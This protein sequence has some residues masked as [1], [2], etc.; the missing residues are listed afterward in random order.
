MREYNRYCIKLA[1][2]NNEA[3]SEHEVRSLK[4]ERENTQNVKSL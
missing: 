1:T 3:S 2:M 4:F